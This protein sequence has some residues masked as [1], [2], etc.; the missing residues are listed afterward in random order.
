[1]LTFKYYSN[2]VNYFFWSKISKL[3]KYCTHSIC[4]KLQHCCHNTSLSSIWHL[5]V[6]KMIITTTV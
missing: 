1:M 6:C 2:K 5:L 4:Y 3:F